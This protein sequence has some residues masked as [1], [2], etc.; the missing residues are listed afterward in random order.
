M[1]FSASTYRNL[2]M[3]SPAARERLIRNG[4]EVLRNCDDTSVNPSPHP[5]TSLD[6][7]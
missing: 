3:E 4:N 5:D 7:S 1:E 2:V 6:R